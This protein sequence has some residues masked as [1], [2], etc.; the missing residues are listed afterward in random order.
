[1]RS[2]PRGKPTSDVEV[3]NVSGHGFWLLIG[4]RELFVPFDRFPW[5]KDVPIGRILKVELPGPD[6]LYWPDMDV[7]LSVES[8]EHP[9]RFPLVSRAR[10]NKRPTKTLQPTSRA[11]PRGSKPSGSGAARG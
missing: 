9:E 7:D 10:P 2:A 8:I 6:H 5:F 1:M 4:K 3:T 11:K